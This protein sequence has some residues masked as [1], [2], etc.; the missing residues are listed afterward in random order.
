MLAPLLRRLTR[1]FPAAIALLCPALPLTAAVTWSDAESGLP[2]IQRFPPQVYRAHGQISDVVI[3]R[4][5]RLYGTTQQALV[6]FDGT[7]WETL[8]FPSLWSWRVDATDDGRVYTAGNDELGYYADEPD[9][10]TV[11]H[12]LMSAVP[13]EALPLGAVRSTRAAG[14]VVGF[15]CDKGWLV[16]ADGRFIFTPTPGASRSWIH[17]VGAVLYASATKT[18]LHRWDGRAWRPLPL[19]AEH[20]ATTVTALG[21]LPDGE[22]LAIAGPNGAFRISADGRAMTPFTGPGGRALA[23]AQAHLLL[24]LP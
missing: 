4:D 23:E 2:A 3:A 11:Y 16:W 12:S 15:S 10:T 8:P 22:L 17:R 6:R 9:G 19:P 1:R 14:N 7:R 20:A 24:A 5:G 13:P 21:A 18:G